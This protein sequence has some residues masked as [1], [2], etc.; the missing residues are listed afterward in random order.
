MPDDDEQADLYLCAVE[1]LARE[2]YEQYEI[3]NFCRPGYP[4]RHN[5]KYWTCAPFI[6][7]GPGP[8]P[9]SAAAGIPSSGTWTPMWKA[10]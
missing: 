9:I 1:E 5:L 4:S 3:S 6:G 10:S 8:S 2:G 7:F